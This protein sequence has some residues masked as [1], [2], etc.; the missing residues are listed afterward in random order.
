MSDD[1]HGEKEPLEPESTPE[2]LDFDDEL[3]PR[4]TPRGRK[5]I[6]AVGALI[7]I[8]LALGLGVGLG[9]HHSAKSSPTATPSPSIWTGG[10]ENATDIKTTLTREE[11]L[12]DQDR[13][14]LSNRNFTISTEPQTRTFNWTLSEVNAAPGGLIKPM[15]VINGMSPGPMLEGNLGDR[16]VINV[17]NNMTN[18]TTIHW[19]GMYL[20]NQN[21]MDGTYSVTQCGIPP[22]GSMTYNWTVQQWG[23][24]WYHAHKAAQYTDGLYGP[25]V[26]HTPNETAMTANKYDEDYT[27]MINDMYNT[28]AS[29]ITWRYEALG[30]GLDGNPGDEPAP[31][32]GMINGVSQ[33]RCAYL[34]ASNDVEPE[35]R[36]DVSERQAGEYAFYPSSNYCGS[37][38]V[39][40]W[41][42]TWVQG[43]TYRIR[44]INPGTFVN[45]IFSIDSHPLTI[46]EADG[47][48]VIPYT[49]NSVDIGVAQ[50]YSVLVTLNQT[51]G[52]YWIRNTLATDQLRYT[53]PDFNATTLGVLRYQGVDPTLMPANLPA[54]SL[55]GTASFDSS[56]LVPADRIDAVP[57][58]KQVF[59]QFG[60]QYTTDKQHYMFFNSSSWTPMAPGQ[61]TIGT[62]K[63]IGASSFSGNA[64]AMSQLQDGRLGS[65]LTIINEKPEY[66]DLI[67]NSL[68]DGDHPFH[69][70]GHTFQIMSMG[71]TGFYEDSSS[72]N[73][74]NPMRRDTVII[75]AYGH[76]VLRIDTSNPGV[77]V[78]HCHITWHMEIGL[79]LAIVDL[80]DEIA[81]FETPNDWNQLCAPDARLGY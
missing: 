18:E 79:L 70:H 7:V 40:Y 67:V 24:S 25:I 9:K 20:R 4:H 58:S 45:T 38:H 23:S 72:L 66:M 8:G 17:Y 30:T 42:V 12:G 47:T 32:G 11:L 5:W 65:Q 60:M 26:L 63:S 77:W 46:I 27:V 35:R 59:V 10:P 62:I 57:P 80:P 29:A 69:L 76:L 54:P 44:L 81:A 68:D 61:S 73:M 13:W 52:A 71:S 55:N 19:H 36:R 16:F 78:F 14:L 33:A 75:P 1:R 2:T 49:V 53:T 31:D 15:I 50:R 74:T 56:Q 34:P 28:Q 37:E 48:S 43:D 22:G 64:S 51:K 3:P 21:F 6:L 39:D 41:N